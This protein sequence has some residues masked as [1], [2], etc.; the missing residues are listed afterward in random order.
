MR[1]FLRL[2]SSTDPRSTVYSDVCE[3]TEQGGFIG[4]GADCVWV[5]ECPD[6]LVSRRHAEVVFD[7]GRFWLADNSV[8]GVFH[9]KND[10]PIGKGQ[11]VVIENG[12]SFR[13]GS[14]LVRAT[15]EDLVGQSEASDQGPEP[16]PDTSSDP[17]ASPD[18]KSALPDHK[19]A[20]PSDK[21]KVSPLRLAD[22]SDA[23]KPPVARI[24]D[25]WEIDLQTPPPREVPALVV[26]R[27]L[28]ALQR[29]PSQ[30]LLSELLPHDFELT[31][32]DVSPEVATAI[33]K[34]LRICL[35]LVWT[36]RA[37][38]DRVDA[39]L[40]GSKR[41]EHAD[42][43][44]ADIERFSRGL[45]Q[46]EQCELRVADLQ[47]LAA[48]LRGRHVALHDSFTESLTTIVEQFQPEKFEERLA[49]AHRDGGFIQ[50]TKRVANRIFPA[51]RLWRFYRSWHEQQQ[52]SDY[53]AVHQLFEKK[54]V[55][56]YRRLNK[57][58]HQELTDLAAADA[59]AEKIAANASK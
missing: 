17:V 9:N 5:L 58:R 16:A 12:D 54:L 32:Q 19:D 4:R 14:F 37:E 30:A 1:L 21:N 13:I 2:D 40:T 51:S 6:R 49:S 38:F 27:R 59:K 57:A 22:I 44:A 29:V 34:S 10:E 24:P 56:V 35:E 53:R 43:F 11:R 48:H 23:F 42:N 39:R 41:D 20:S 33:G 47:Q 45:L 15:T 8:N 28:N 55:S 46:D 50:F 18:P 25:D 26:N 3:F 31:D 36:L 7:D 52:G